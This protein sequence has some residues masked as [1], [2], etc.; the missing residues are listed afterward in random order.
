VHEL[1]LYGKL[2]K[3]R[4]IMR[5]EVAI[6]IDDSI[7]FHAKLEK[8][9]V[10]VCKKLECQVPLWLD[11]NTKEFVLYRKTFFSKEQFIESVWFDKLEIRIEE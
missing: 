2:I 6:N 11:K 3:E 10:E 9:L 7:S 8:C 5:E 1:K 4:K